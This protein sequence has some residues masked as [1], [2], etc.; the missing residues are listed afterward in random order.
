M[1][2]KDSRG[3]GGIYWVAVLPGH[4][5]EGIGRAL[6]LAAMGDL[7]GLPMVLCATQLG[8]PLYRTLGFSTALET[9]YWRTGL[10]A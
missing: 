6:M 3:V 4:R 8:A 10:P 2:V 5:R 9:T 7:A 1:T